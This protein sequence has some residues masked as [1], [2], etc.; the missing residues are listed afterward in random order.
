LA[1]VIR[2]VDFEDSCSADLR[3]QMSIEI[4]VSGENIPDSRLQSSTRELLRDLKIQVDPRA[5]LKK[6]PAE[7]N[8]RGDV[9]LIGQIAMALVTGGAVTT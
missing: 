3:P 7:P 2:G 1:E 5:E 6:L 8:S 4:T 9:F